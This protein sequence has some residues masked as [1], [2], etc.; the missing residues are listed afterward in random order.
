MRLLVTLLLLAIVTAVISFRLNKSST[1]TGTLIKKDHKPDYYMEN[2][3]TLTMNLDGTP[4][5]KLF[6]DYLAHYP[7][8]DTT[9]LLKPKLEL[10]HIDKP[11]TVITSEKGW[12][13]SNN[14]VIL[15]SGNVE[16]IHLDRNGEL[17]LQVNT[18]DVKILTE[19]DYAETNQHATVLGRN[20][21]VEAIGVRAYMRESR[22]ELL[23][24]VKGKLLPN[25]D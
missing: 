5:N 7:N 8:D 10:Y 4:K 13:T 14:E 25:N 24:N 11:P 20:S 23:S 6:A 22:I 18:S 16:L 1:D 17:E 3:S 2:F 21:R 19:E 12:I 9:E 15:L